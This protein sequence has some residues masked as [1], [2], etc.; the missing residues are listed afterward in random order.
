MVCKVK[1]EE[2]NFLKHIETCLR[3]TE[4]ANKGESA[5]IRRKTERLNG[6]HKEA[7][8]SF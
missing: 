6:A 7:L 8:L 5:E 1:L 4:A 3:V 2:A